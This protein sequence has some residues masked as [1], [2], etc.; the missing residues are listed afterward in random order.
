MLR[1]KM[2]DEAV[3]YLF[4]RLSSQ[5]L[6]TR[7]FKQPTEENLK[8]DYLWRLHA[9]MPERGVIAARVFNTVQDEPLPD[10]IKND[11]DI[12]QKRF[13]HVNDFEN[14]LAEN[15][16]YTVKVYLHISKD[17]QKERL[18]DRIENPDKNWEFSFS[19][20][21]DREHWHEHM[22][23]FEDTF[24]HTSTDVSPWFVIPANHGDYG[25]L[26]ISEI[27]LDKLQELNPQFPMPS[28]D[29]K[30]KMKEAAKE[31]REGKYD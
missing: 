10:Y 1:E 30:V 25:R 15:G 13:K 23:A 29:E 3:R 21:T 19:D 22:E 24:Q 11:T 12:W 28:D 31:L 5:A 9:A 8:H 16:F 20:L 7:V 6:R 17:I 2:R 4:S 26:I 14:F 18:L 27:L